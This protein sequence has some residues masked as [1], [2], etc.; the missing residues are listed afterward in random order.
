M[1]GSTHARPSPL[2][3][4]QPDPGHPFSYRDSPLQLPRVRSCADLAGRCRFAPPRR[5][6]QIGT[7]A[8][9]EICRR[10]VAGAV[11][12]STLLLSVRRAGSQR[13]RRVTNGQAWLRPDLSARRE[14]LHAWL[15]FEG[16]MDKAAEGGG[17]SDEAHAGLRQRSTRSGSQR[18]CHRW[19][20]IVC[21]PAKCHVGVQL[22]S[23]PSQQSA[24][25][26]D[27]PPPLAP[28]RA[29]VRHRRSVPGPSTAS[30]QQHPRRV[31][32]AARCG[33]CIPVIE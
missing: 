26:F 9:G 1:E 8:S 23:V 11:R 3:R 13:G 10:S 6:T 20:W 32:A 19:A 33:R 14:D 27:T 15:G 29:P 17:A 28:E 25:G 5:S 30:C 4:P 2:P 21:S 31:V 22:I 7:H 16:R 12:D 24:R 18:G